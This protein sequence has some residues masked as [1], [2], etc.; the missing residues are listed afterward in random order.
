MTLNS[1]IIT[2]LHPR[3]LV[4]ELLLKKKKK[5]IVLL[6]SASSGSAP[7]VATVVAAGIF[8]LG[9]LATFEGPF[10]TAVK[11]RNKQ[12]AG[13]NKAHE[14]TGDCPPRSTAAK[15]P[16]GLRSYLRSD[17]LFLDTLQHVP[18]LWGVWGNL[19]FYFFLFV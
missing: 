13:E 9:H 6:P 12:V 4:S 14:E 18:L 11:K 8:K 2:P 19:G 17:A 7:A 15:I 10:H 16:P 1:A 5:R 3:H